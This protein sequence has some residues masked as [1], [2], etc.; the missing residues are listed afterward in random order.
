MA[1][2]LFAGFFGFFADDGL[3]LGFFAAKPPRTWPFDIF[4]DPGRFVTLPEAPPLAPA[5]LVFAASPGARFFA[6]V[7]DDAFPSVTP[8]AASSNEARQIGVRKL[9]SD[10][11]QRFPVHT[12]G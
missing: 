1:A 9:W 5:F 3:A 7:F 11:S 10:S 6:K 4:L 2:A 8:A 12:M